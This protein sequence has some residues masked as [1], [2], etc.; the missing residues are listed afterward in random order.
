MGLYRRAA[1]KVATRR[2]TTRDNDRIRRQEMLS[3]V[4]DCRQHSFRQN[5][6]RESLGHQKVRTGLYVAA[7][8]ELGG[9]FC[10]HFDG[11]SK[12][13]ESDNLARSCG[14]R[15]HDLARSSAPASG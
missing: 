1:N 14:D 12:S 5:A 11:I 6:T 3:S 13:V 15:G 2:R 10:V 7:N 4:L 9:M 8:L